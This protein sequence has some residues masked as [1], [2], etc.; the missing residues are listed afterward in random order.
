MQL[1]VTGG[2]GL[3]GRLRV[4][5]DKSISHRGLILGALAQGTSRVRGFLAAADCLATLRCVRALGVEVE[6]VAPSPTADEGRPYRDYQSLLPSLT[7]HV[8]GKGLEG[9]QEPEDVLDCGGSGTTI[10]LLA[11]LLAGRPFTS[12]LTGNAQLR[13]RP[14]G[15][16][17]TPLRQMGAEVLGRDEG[18]LPPLAIRGGGLHGL[19]YTLPVASAQV[20]SAI[21]LA[22][23]SADGPTTVREPGPARDHTERMLH[24]QGVGLRVDGYVITLEPP[25]G[26]LHPLDLDVPGDFSSAAFLI[27]AACLAP[28]SDIYLE[29]VGLNPTRTGLLDVLRN[30][31]AMIT[32]LNTRET[33]GEPTGD[34]VVQTSA[35]RG[36]EV[37]GDLVVRMIDEF[38]ALAV[39]ATQ[40]EGPT[41]VRDASELRVK[42]SDRI[43][44]V[45]TELLKMGAQ[46]EERADGFV[47]EGPTPLHGAIVESH[48]D[49]RLA[50]ALILAGLIAEGET[51]VTEAECIGD[52]FPGFVGTLRH[53]GAEVMSQ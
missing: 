47:V 26:P 36:V 17:V 39:A 3:H 51:A 5:G 38:P 20:K 2:R 32:W 25:A 42:E 41:V 30:M 28:Q 27:I 40:A 11:G 9:L 12:V 43:N 1:T 21:M 31:G 15:R 50:M 16:V 19:D 18:R 14:M 7:L 33:A 22:A 24:A 37:S 45:V 4:P 10:R 35:L 34:L 49:H 48:G 44:T 46:I 52:S 23:L 13:R 53:L 8:H 6:E 29:G